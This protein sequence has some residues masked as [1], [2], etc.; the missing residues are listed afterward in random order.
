MSIGTSISLPNINVSLVE[1]IYYFPTMLVQ[2][3]KLVQFPVDLCTNQVSSP[4][5]SPRDLIFEARIVPCLGHSCPVWSIPVA[6]HLSPL[7]LPLHLRRLSHSIERVR[8]A[9]AYTVCHECSVEVTFTQT[10]YG[11]LIA[12]KPNVQ[13]NKTNVLVVRTERGKPKKN[14]FRG[15]TEKNKERNCR[16]NVEGE[17]ERESPLSH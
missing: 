11:C 10:R 1:C 14:Q 9:F 15:N 7:S 8:N 12:I 17:R 3:Y 5:P 4:T 6:D 13:D 2:R 16:L